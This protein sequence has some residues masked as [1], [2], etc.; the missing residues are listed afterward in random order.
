MGYWYDPNRDNTDVESHFESLLFG[1]IP[2][3]QCLWVSPEAVPAIGT[4]VQVAYLGS[5][6]TKQEWPSKENEIVKE[7]DPV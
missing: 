3:T 4:W 1:T 5:D 2:G 7:K 6:P